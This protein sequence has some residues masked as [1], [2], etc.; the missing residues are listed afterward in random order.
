MCDKQSLRSVCRS[1]EYSMTVELLTEHRLEFLSLK[2]GITGL[3]EST[4][5]KM[6]LCWKSHAVAQIMSVTCPQAS[7]H[8]SELVVVE[9][10]LS[11]TCHVGSCLLVSCHILSV[12]LYSYC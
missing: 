6:P 9:K 8:V 10:L 3:S 12:Y 2:G 1:F 5:V 7:G 11:L 4:R